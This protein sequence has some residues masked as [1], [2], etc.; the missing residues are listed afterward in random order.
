MIFNIVVDAVVREMLDVVCGPK[1]VRHGVVWEAV[2]RNL[3]FYM[4]DG[5]I[6]GR[7]H[8]WVQDIWVQDGLMVT[9]AMLRR[10]GLETN[11]E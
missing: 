3:V 9:V 5:R 1:E 4:D 2:E 10:L 8:I 6:V 11:I 7:D